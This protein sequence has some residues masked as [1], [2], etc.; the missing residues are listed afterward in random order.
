M[1]VFNPLNSRYFTSAPDLYRLTLTCGRNEMKIAQ[2]E[3]VPTT[4]PSHS[5]E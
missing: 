2:Y 1:S 5:S 4:P 3:H